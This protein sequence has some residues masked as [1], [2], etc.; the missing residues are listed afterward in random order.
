MRISLHL[1]CSFYV[2]YSTYS[3]CDYRLLYRF[4]RH[5]ERGLQIINNTSHPSHSLSNSWSIHMFIGQLYRITV[6]SSC[7]KSTSDKTYTVSTCSTYAINVVRDTWI[8]TPSTKDR[9]N[10]SDYWET[11]NCGYIYIEI[12]HCGDTTHLIIVYFNWNITTS[13]FF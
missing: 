3:A 1:S 9:L 12:H 6:P 8:L 13:F 11:I 5:C 2:H 10:F 7:P 4:A